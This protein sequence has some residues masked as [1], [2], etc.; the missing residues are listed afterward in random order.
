M[1]KPRRRV[2][3]L[4]ILQEG[5]NKSLNVDGGNIL[6]ENRQPILQE[7]TDSE[8]SDFKFIKGW[9]KNGRCS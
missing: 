4:R 2:D 9:K 3:Y 7:L 6:Q 8:I 1:I 5:V